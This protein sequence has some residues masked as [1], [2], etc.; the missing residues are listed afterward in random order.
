MLSLLLEHDALRL[1]YRA[2]HQDDDR[3]RGTALEYL[4]TVLPAEVRDAI[5]PL[6]GAAEGPLPNQRA[7][8]DLLSD[9]SKAIKI[10]AS[11]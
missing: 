2:L 7:S 1:C 10:E 9:L 11:K 8:K 3:Y 4:E 5:W 6:L